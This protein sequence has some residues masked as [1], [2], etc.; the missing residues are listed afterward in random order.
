MVA[1]KNNLL[2]FQFNFFLVSGKKNFDINFIM[3]FTVIV[4]FVAETS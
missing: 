2:F 1:D 4:A 3:L